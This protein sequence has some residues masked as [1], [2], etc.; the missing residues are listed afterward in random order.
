MMVYLVHGQADVFSTKKSAEAHA[1]KWISDQESHLNQ[2]QRKVL[3]C[4]KEHSDTDAV[5][6]FY[7]ECCREGQSVFVHETEIIEG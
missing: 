7:N 6:R 2:Y 3:K 5:I 1:L 4:L